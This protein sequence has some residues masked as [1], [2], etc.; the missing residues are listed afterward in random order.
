MTDLALAVN[1]GDR[2]PSSCDA[3]L[4]KRGYGVNRGQIMQTPARHVSMKRW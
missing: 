1:R 2:L 4:V 3:V